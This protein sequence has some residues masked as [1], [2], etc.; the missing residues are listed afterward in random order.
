VKEGNVLVVSRIHVEYHL[1]LDLEK[2]S[3]AER[4]H[5][6]HAENCPV[7]RTIRDCVK[8]TTS[9]NVESL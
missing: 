9:L 8:I 1:K 6:I 4:A 7:A 3:E 5:E 2:L